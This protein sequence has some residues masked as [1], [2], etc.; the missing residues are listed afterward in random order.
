MERNKRKQKVV[1]G[2]LLARLAQRQRAHLRNAAD[3]RQCRQEPGK[4]RQEQRHLVIDA[5]HDEHGDERDQR[6]RA[7][8]LRAPADPGHGG[9]H[10]VDGQLGLE[11][12]FVLSRGV[13]DVV[14]IETVGEFFGDEVPQQQAPRLQR[15]IFVDEGEAERL[16][17]ADPRD[18]A[19]RPSRPSGRHGLRRAPPA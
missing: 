9:Q 13:E 19:R 6:E 18:D 1:F 4:R 14:A 8:L 2:I 12:R 7:D 5:V 10:L 16:A 17:A 11:G 3:R 15:N